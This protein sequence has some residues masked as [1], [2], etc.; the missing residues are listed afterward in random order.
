LDVLLPERQR[1]VAKETLEIYTPLAHRLGIWELKW[2]LEDLS[3]R[4]VEPE[5]YYQI[6]NLIAAQRAQRESFI[7]QVTQILSRELGKVGLRAEMSGRPKHIYSIHQKMERYS[8]LGKDFDDIHDL[9]ALR[10]L[11]DTMP[12]CYSA[13]GVIHSLWRPLPG[14]FDDF[15]ANPK[16]N[17]YQ[18]LH[19]VVIYQGRVPLEVQIR[20]HD[21]HHIAGYG[22]AAHWYYIASIFRYERPQAGRYRQH[23]QF[24]YEAIGDDDP[25]LDAEVID[26]AWQFFLSLNLHP[27]HLNG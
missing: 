20:T 19:T 15:I 18:S 3:F 13:L 27:Q 11:V 10:V 12:D 23:Y 16:P 21:M 7:T 5:R 24:G 17:G 22:V 2:Q 6:V 14:E 26:M 1:S 25:A 9:Q 4:Y 8:A